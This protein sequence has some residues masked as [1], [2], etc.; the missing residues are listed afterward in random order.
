MCRAHYGS[1]GLSPRATN[2]C[3]P[4]GAKML[5]VLMFIHFCSRGLF[6]RAATTCAPDG[7]KML[8]MLMFT[9][10]CYRV[11]FPGLQPHVLLTGLNAVS[12]GTPGKQT[13]CFASEERMW[14]MIRISLQEMKCLSS[15]HSASIIFAHW[16]H[17]LHMAL[18]PA[19]MSDHRNYG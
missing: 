9:H 12:Q 1:R 16:L 14:W 4:D 13:K 8:R 17:Q 2:T 6:P 5:R 10:F 11:C 7:A 3:A 15:L 18:R 19:T